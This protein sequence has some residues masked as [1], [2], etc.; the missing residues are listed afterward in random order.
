MPSFLEHYG[1]YAP[2][3]Y[4][5]EIPRELDEDALVLLKSPVSLPAQLARELKALG[6]LVRADVVLRCRTININ[7]RATTIPAHFQNGG[8]NTTVALNTMKAKI[9]CNVQKYLAER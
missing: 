2:E 6:Y 5:D 8:P 9:P 1:E 7:E 3:Y 4:G